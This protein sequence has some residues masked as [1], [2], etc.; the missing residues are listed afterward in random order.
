MAY[1]KVKVKRNGDR[2]SPCFKP[3][4][5]GNVSDRCL[6]TRTLLYVSL[7]HIFINFTSFMG[8]PNP[9]H[10]RVKLKYF[11]H[12]GIVHFYP[13]IQAFATMLIISVLLSGTAQ[14]RVVA[15]YRRFGTKYRCHLQGSAIQEDFLTLVDRTDTLS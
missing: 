7:R 9:A 8:I 3:F 5:I 1:S 6:P 2:A 12:A 4:L 15:F 11:L 14:R 10:T 13:Q